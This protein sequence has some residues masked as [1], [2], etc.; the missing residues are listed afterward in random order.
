MLT[1]HVSVFVIMAKRITVVL[2]DQVVKKLRIIQS[3]KISKSNKSISFSSV[4]NEELR[5]VMK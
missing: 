4:I 5:K 2:D 3:K 1:H